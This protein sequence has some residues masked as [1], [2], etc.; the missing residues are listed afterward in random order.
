MAYRYLENIAKADAAFEVKAE[1]LKGLFKDAALALFGL[2]VDLN[3]VE[4]KESRQIILENKKIEDLLFD[5]L[6]ELVFLKDKDYILFKEFQIDISFNKKYKLKA[7]AKGEMINP[8][9]HKLEV[10]V[11]AITLH[12]FKVE[13]KNKIWYARIVVDI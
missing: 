4:A 10:D 7:Q 11:K 5:F 13:Q 3:S 1:S 12:L 2:M 6:E 9:K 8:Q